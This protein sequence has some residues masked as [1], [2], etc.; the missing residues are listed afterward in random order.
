M[1]TFLS[2]DATARKSPAGENFRSEIESSGGDDSA[3]SL[4]GSPGALVEAAEAALPK[5]PAM[6]S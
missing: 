5:R 3:T 1:R 6:R 2:H 4:E